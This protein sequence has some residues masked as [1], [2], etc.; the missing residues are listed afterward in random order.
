MD[1]CTL[2]PCDE[3]DGFLGDSR[4]AHA[5]ACT[6]ARMRS[7]MLPQKRVT[8]VTARH[9][10]QKQAFRASPTRHNLV[11]N[12]VTTRHARGGRSRRS[13]FAS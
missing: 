11:T 9:R 6:H 7:C 1:L 3:G 4:Y 2:P 12:P 5:R 13:I 10:S 8:L